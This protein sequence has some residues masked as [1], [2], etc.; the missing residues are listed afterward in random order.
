MQDFT[1]FYSSPGG[2][3]THDCDTFEAAFSLLKE[4]EKKGNF[5][6]VLIVDKN[7]NIVWHNDKIGLDECMKMAKEYDVI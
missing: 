1:L 5:T 7:K 6:A 4:K 3:G 2:K